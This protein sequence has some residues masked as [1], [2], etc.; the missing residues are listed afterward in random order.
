[1]DLEA[2]MLLALGSLPACSQ[3]AFEKDELPLPLIVVSQENRRVL[4]RA[5][6]APYLEEA[7]VSAHVYAK[8]LTELN[9]L[10]RQAHEALTAM[11]LSCLSQARDH[12][13]TAWA[14]HHLFRYRA[15]IHGD[16]IYQ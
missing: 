8:T 1:M 14:Y 3:S 2:A 12:D 9:A 16:T 6:G 7:E 11:G 10:S 5:D 13:E 15:V 4:A